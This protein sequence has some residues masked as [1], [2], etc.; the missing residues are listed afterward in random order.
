[1]DAII[2][3]T[4]RSVPYADVGE[5]PIRRPSPRTTILQDSDGRSLQRPAP[6]DT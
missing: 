1:M 2:G 4:R 3:T 6:V 5:S